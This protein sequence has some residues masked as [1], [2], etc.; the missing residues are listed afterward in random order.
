MVGTAEHGG[1]LVRIGVLEERAPHHWHE[2]R[3]LANI[4]DRVARALAQ[5]A[6][7]DGADPRQWR[8]TFEPVSRTDWVVVEAFRDGTW[9]PVDLV[10]DEAGGT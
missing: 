5:V 3:R 10:E 2:I 7:R 1:G 4:E 6:R 8:G 9:I